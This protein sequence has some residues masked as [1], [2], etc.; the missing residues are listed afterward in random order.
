LQLTLH[1]DYSLRVLLYLAEHP[2]TVSST[3]EIAVFYGISRHHLVR[4]VQTLNANSFVRVATGRGGGAV[5]ARSPSEINL[6]DVVRKTEPGFRIVECFEPETNTCGIVSDCRLRG[7]LSEALQAFFR[8][9]D[10]YTLADLVS[11]KRVRRAVA[12]VP[13]ESLIGKA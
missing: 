8:T 7:A 12:D 13:L 3:E 2:E 11:E 4:V 10:R 1:A 9:L 6:G 5:L